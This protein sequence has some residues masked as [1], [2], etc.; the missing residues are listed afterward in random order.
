M[1]FFSRSTG[2]IPTSDYISSFHSVIRRQANDG[3]GC[4]LQ[5]GKSACL[6]SVHP[7]MNAEFAKLHRNKQSPGDPA[8]PQCSATRPI[9]RQRWVN[10]S[11]G[12][13]LS[14]PRAMTGHPCIPAADARVVDV[15]THMQTN[16]RY[17]LIE[18]HIITIQNNYRARKDDEPEHRFYG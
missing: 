2:G 1:Q 11:P 7:E 5:G 6:T 17:G 16:N 13:L 18:Q 8:T 9:T 4:V 15:M 12:D 14:R 3:T 10:R